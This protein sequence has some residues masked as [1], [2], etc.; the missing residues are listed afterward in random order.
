MLGC[1]LT[2]Q[3]DANLKIGKGDDGIAM[4]KTSYQSLIGKLIYLNHT[5]P[6]ISFAVSLVNQFMSEPYDILLQAAYRILAYLTYTIGQG[7]SIEAYTDSDWVG[8][9]VDKRYTL[10]CSTFVGGSLIT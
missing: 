10:E 4:D 6:Y 8:S 5:C 7:L 9:V 1:L 2:P 3:F